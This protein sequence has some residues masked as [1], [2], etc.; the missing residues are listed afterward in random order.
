[1]TKNSDS[2]RPTRE[3]DFELV[4]KIVLVLSIIGIIVSTTLIF[5]PPI[6]GEEY[7]ELGILTYNVETERFE[8]DNYPSHTFYNSTEGRS[9]LTTLYLFVANHYQSAKFFEIRMKIGLQ[10]TTI[11]EN[12][13]GNND[14]TYFYEEHWIQ[15]AFSEDEQ[16]GPST[17][18]KIEFRFTETIIDKLGFNSDGYKIIFELW[19]YDTSV[20]DFD[21]TGV[22]VYLTSFKLVIIS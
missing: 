16:F 7:A 9:N 4:A 5:T 15:R 22:H 21:Y 12:Y 13:F 18:S 14:S 8:A 6:S 11:N 3:L 20:S 1:M 17:L 10:N 19:E 2:K